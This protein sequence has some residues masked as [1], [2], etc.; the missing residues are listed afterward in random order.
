MSTH[1]R[2]QCACPSC[3]LLVRGWGVTG[4]NRL[5]VPSLQLVA[6]WQLIPDG[7]DRSQPCERVCVSSARSSLICP[8]EGLGHSS[9][10]LRNPGQWPMAVGT[11]IA[12]RRQHVRRNDRSTPKTTNGARDHALPPVSS[13][14]SGTPV[15]GHPPA[16]DSRSIRN[17]SRLET[18]FAASPTSSARTHGAIR[19]AQST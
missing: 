4:K 9:L 3:K 7:F 17:T 6:V 12:D 11:D 2:W 18:N 16:I 1:T 10:M 5:P 13:L 19:S 14:A 8:L 15:P